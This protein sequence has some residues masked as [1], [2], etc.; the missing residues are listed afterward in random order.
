MRWRGSTSH[1]KIRTLQSIVIIAS[2]WAYAVDEKTL[3]IDLEWLSWLPSE[4]MVSGSIKGENSPTSWDQYVTH[5]VLPLQ[6]PGK[7]QALL[8]TSLSECTVIGVDLA[9]ARGR[10]ENC[11]SVFLSKFLQRFVYSTAIESGNLNNQSQTNTS[12]SYESSMLRS[13]SMRRLRLVSKS[14]WLE[15]PT[16]MILSSSEKL[17]NR[18]QRMER[19]L[20]ESGWKDHHPELQFIQTDA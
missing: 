7:I 13:S 9:L 11:S 20:R 10:K 15:R 17:R 19:P 3:L 2:E 12:S 18:Q 14:S 4:P 1:T 5:Q 16:C 8:R 6:I